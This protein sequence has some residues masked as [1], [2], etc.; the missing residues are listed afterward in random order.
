MTFLVKSPTPG[1]PYRSHGIARSL[2]N[3][4]PFEVEVLDPEPR[5]TYAATCK[6]KQV[7]PVSPSGLKWLKRHECE[8]SGTDFGRGRSY[9]ISELISDLQPVVAL[10]RALPDLTGEVG[11]LKAELAEKEE[12][13]RSEANDAWENW[14]SVKRLKSELDRLNAFLGPITWCLKCNGNGKDGV[15]RPEYQMGA[16]CPIGHASECECLVCLWRRAGYVKATRIAELEAKLSAAEADTKRMDVLRNNSTIHLR[17][18]DASVR[19]GVREELIYPAQDLRLE[20]D[21]LSAAMSAQGRSKRNDRPQRLE[22]RL[23]IR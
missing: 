21:K 19:Y 12:K 7:Y 20:I 11:R 6:C 16:C 8:K 2:H 22:R 18:P 3:A 9:G 15:G 10:L 1:S 5:T 17:V 14:E 23:A 13:R 4:L